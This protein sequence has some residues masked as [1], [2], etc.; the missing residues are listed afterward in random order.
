MDQDPIQPERPAEVL[1]IEAAID[2]TIVLCGGDPRDAI[3][4]LLIAN[5]FLEAERDR[6]TSLISNGYARGLARRG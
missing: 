2:A 3:R 5:D 1:E 4:A 6:L